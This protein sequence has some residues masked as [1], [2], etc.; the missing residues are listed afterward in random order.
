MTTTR[1]YRKAMSQA[2]ADGELLSDVKRGRLD[3]EIVRVFL[4]LDREALA[5]RDMELRFAGDDAG[6]PERVGHPPG[7]DRRHA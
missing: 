5:N 4:E 2:D 1:P 6:H 3:A 7:G